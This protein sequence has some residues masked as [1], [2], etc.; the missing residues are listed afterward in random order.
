[1]KRVFFF[2]LLAL[3]LAACNVAKAETTLRVESAWARPAPAG[4]NG[5]V[6]FTIV[7]TGSTDTLLSVQTDVADTVELHMSMAH[8]GAMQMQ[9]Q[10]EIA[11]PKGTTEFRPGGYHVMLLG[12]RREL[13]P[14]D[15]FPLALN[16][17]R[18]GKIIVTVTVKE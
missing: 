4:E 14:G 10:H 1:M 13:K 3:L 11:I 5:A 12:L 17:K 8:D 7:N 15:S 18:A 9:M 6:Y 2:A 16:F